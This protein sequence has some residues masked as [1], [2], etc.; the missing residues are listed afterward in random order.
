[1][2]AMVAVIVLLGGAVVWSVLGGSTEYE[3]TK[4]EFPP[5]DQYAS[6]YE[7]VARE[8]ER[9]MRD[10]DPKLLDERLDWN[11]IFEEANKGFDPD[12]TLRENLVTNLFTPGAWGSDLIRAMGTTG[13]YRFM[14]V[15]EVDGEPRILFRLVRADGSPDYHEYVPV[16]APDGKILF[17]DVYVYSFGEMLSRTTQRAA[18]PLLTITQ[19]SVL[20]RL[21][22]RPDEYVDN[23]NKII[24]IAKYAKEG[25]TEADSTA[26]A[27]YNSLPP[28]VQRDKNLLITRLRIAEKNPTQAGY[29]RTVERITNDLETDP[30]LDLLLLRHRLSRG[31]SRELQAA[32]R[33]LNESVGGDPYLKVIQGNI[34]F[35]ANDPYVAKLFYRQAL[36]AEPTLS[37]AYEALIIVGLQEREF[38]TVKRLLLEYELKTPVRLDDL[39]KSPLYAEFIKT[40]E[41]R[42]WLE[43][44]PKARSGSAPSGR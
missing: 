19:R 15:R 31:D 18:L 43:E 2:G 16:V 12:P 36:E 9:T 8:I 27:I 38:N 30:A 37:Y 42:D 26:V 44:R 34:R 24:E 22:S 41:Y 29:N 28:S 40:R 39:E 17:A 33:E 7:A 35:F 1:M 6:Q 20:A 3:P 11:A 4:R 25:T 5:F 21:F 14:R 10:R 23:C 32:L 13:S